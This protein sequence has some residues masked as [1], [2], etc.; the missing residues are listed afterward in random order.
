V[1]LT[2]SALARTIRVPTPPPDSSNFRAGAG[3]LCA[4]SAVR[5]YRLPDRLRG[6]V[7]R[8][9]A[10]P[11][12]SRIDLPSHCRSFARSA[13]LRAAPRHER[14]RRDHRARSA[15]RPPKAMSRRSRSARSL[16][17]TA[18]AAN[19]DRHAAC[20]CDFRLIGRSL[21][22]MDHS[23]A[24]KPPKTGSDPSDLF[25]VPP[26]ISGIRCATHPMHRRK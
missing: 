16:R 17:R 11:G 12:A 10:A 23:P 21:P 26:P 15:R 8:R 4:D 7:R 25:R 19:S 1:K 5:D 3:P 9:A 20:R 2:D 22:A 13:C 24:P 6:A 14:Q 18:W